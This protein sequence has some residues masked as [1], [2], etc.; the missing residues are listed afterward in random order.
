MRIMRAV[1]ALALAGASTGCAYYSRGPAYTYAPAP[2][3]YTSD[4]YVVT[5]APAP[6]YYYPYSSHWDYYRNYHGVA[7]PGPEYYP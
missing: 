5:T 7:H 1:L 6:A 2:A 4:A 3:Y